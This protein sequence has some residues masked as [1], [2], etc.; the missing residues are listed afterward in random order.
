MSNKIIV[1][2]IEVDED[3]NEL[4]SEI[5]STKEII[6][7]T[8]VSNFG[9]DQGEQLEIMGKVQ[10]SMIEMQADFLKSET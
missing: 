2:A 7:P 6:P 10:Q 3:G 1:K 4:S 8:D 9:Y 5:L